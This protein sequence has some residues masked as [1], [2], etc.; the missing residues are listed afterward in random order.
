MFKELGASAIFKL[1]D[2]LA[3]PS[4]AMFAPLAIAPVATPFGQRRKPSFPLLGKRPPVEQQGIVPDYEETPSGDDDYEQ[5]TIEDLPTDLESLLGNTGKSGK[6]GDYQIGPKGTKATFG[7][8][9]AFDPGKAIGQVASMSGSFITAG[10]A[11]QKNLEQLQYAQAMAGL[12]VKDMVWV[13]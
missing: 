6:L 10:A 13:L 11:G 5:V 3:I 9:Q 1:E 8:T 4:V 12:G 2:E 7:V